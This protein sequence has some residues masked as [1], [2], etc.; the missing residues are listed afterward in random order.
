MMG[1]PFG[2]PEPAYKTEEE[3]RYDA[4]CK[5][6]ERAVD[7]LEAQEVTEIRAGLMGQDYAYIHTDGG[8]VVEIGIPSEKVIPLIEEGIAYMQAEGDHTIL[9]TTKRRKIRVHVWT[10]TVCLDEAREGDLPLFKRRKA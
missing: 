5:R 1:D 7:L 2:S 6:Q 10:L 8:S 9:F 4:A 3:K